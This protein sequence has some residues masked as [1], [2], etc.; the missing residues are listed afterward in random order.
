MMEHTIKALQT[1]IDSLGN[2]M[3]KGLDE[4]KEMISGFDARVRAVELKENEHNV[5]MA[6]SLDAA[7]KRIDERKT[8]SQEDK[9][10]FNEKILKIE[11]DIKGILKTIDELVHTNKILKWIL[12]VMTTLVVGLLTKWILGG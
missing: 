8:E 12:T 3:D 5:K 4:L 1:Q 2:R 6:A 9:K 10:D 7:W 11:T